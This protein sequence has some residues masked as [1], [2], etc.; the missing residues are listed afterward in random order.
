MLTSVT[1]DRRIQKLHVR[2]QL[3][4]RPVSGC[5]L[6]R[7]WRDKRTFHIQGGAYGVPVGM[8]LVAGQPHLPEIV[9]W[10]FAYI[11]IYIYVHTCVSHDSE[12]AHVHQS[13]C[14]HSVSNMVQCSITVQHCSTVQRCNMPPAMLHRIATFNAAL[15]KWAHNIVLQHSV[16][17][18][19]SGGGG[20]G[21]GTR[22]PRSIPVQNWKLVMTNVDRTG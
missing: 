4:K 18:R 5:G 8:E 2:S 14:A 13:T 20:S 16:K 6:V 10:W 7:A 21:T 9:A 3:A 11:H 19:Y 17:K 22:V 12:R 15:R 1:L